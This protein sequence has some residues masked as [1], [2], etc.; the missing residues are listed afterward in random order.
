MSISLSREEREKFAT[1]AEQQ[2]H[3]D[4]LMAEQAG[5]MVVVELTKMLRTRAL[6]YAIVAKDLRSVEDVS[7]G[8]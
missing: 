6:S 4:N 2:A 1:Y 3:D 5:K 7:I 8:G